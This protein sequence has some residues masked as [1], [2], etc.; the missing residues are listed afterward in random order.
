MVKIILHLNNYLFKL[1]I[2]LKM[3]LIYFDT[4]IFVKRQTLL[5]LLNYG[6]VSFS[7]NTVYAYILY[8]SK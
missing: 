6:V 3:L 5:F 7:R 2:V 1:D 8:K 4:L